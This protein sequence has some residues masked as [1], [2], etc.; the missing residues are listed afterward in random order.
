MDKDK[1]PPIPTP[2][3]QHWREFRIQILPFIVFVAILVGVVYL[4]KNYVQPTGI[5]GAAETNM[6]AVI[7]LQ[8][9]VINALYVERF[10]SVTQGQDIAVI[11]NTDPELL[12]AQVATAQ[13]EFEVTRRRMLVGEWGVDQSLAKY[14]E[15]ELEQR[16]LIGTA[17][18]KLILA[19]ADLARAKALLT[20]QI[21]SQAA[22]DL[23]KAT[24]DALTVEIAERET[25]VAEMVKTVAEI[26]PKD[27][28]GDHRPDPIDVAIETK[29][30]E[31]QL[32]LKPITLKAPINGMVSAVHHLVHERI[33]RGTSIVSISD[34]V[35]TRIVAYV[36]QPVTIVPKL[37]DS[38]QITTRSPLRLTGRGQILRIGAQMEPINSA[39]LSADAKRM[40]VGLPILVSVPP[41]IRLLP[42]EYV[43][44]FIIKERK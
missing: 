40:E 31:L 44:L 6:V 8:D 21:N 14:R 10:Q 18:V 36:R 33:V 27:K 43:D 23:A 37:N 26:R 25:L 3:S 9:G 41:E 12:K 5:I 30:L 32:M 29:S 34:P 13:A 1:L 17:K 2:A 28:P 7:S 35:T 15:S 38:V 11:F 39:L 20:S 19:S 4:W 22:Y 16:V 42:G 24:F